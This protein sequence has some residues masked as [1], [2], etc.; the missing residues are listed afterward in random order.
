MAQQMV[1][2]ILAAGRGT[3]LHPLN[4]DYPKPL[5][6]VCNKPIIRYHLEDMQRVG[7]DEVFVVV[8]H[9]KEQMAR[10]LA[11]TER[12][13]GM[14]IH[15][16]DQ[17]QP[18]GIAHAVLQLEKHIDKP[19]LVF[20]GD[21]FMVAPQLPTMLALFEE[22]QAGAVLAVKREP[23][24]AVLRRNFSV[25]VNAE[26]RVTRVVEKPRVVTT[27]L[28][29]CG[30][31]LFN[32]DFFDALRRTP[33]TAQRDE[34]EITDSIQLF[35]DWGAKVYPAAVIERDINITLAADLLDCNIQELDLRGLPHAIGRDVVLPEGS[36]IVRSVIGDGVVFTQPVTVRDSIIFDG[37]RVNE[38]GL[39]ERSLVT[40]TARLQFGERMI[41][42]RTETAG[43]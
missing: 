20:L 36:E 1:G 40:P 25:I 21:I 30:I 31:Y 7:I 4:V 28:K 38:G 41:I 29:G 33:R 37:V 16:V 23:D 14:R 26:G 24:P 3:R 22:H 2:V 27:D 12:D 15:H 39:F 8:G 43:A 18:L 5:L 19:F 11:Q 10:V 42:T 17:G 9:L 32:P 34:Y 35:L 13:L 6:P